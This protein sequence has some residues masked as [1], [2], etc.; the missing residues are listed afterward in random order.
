[1]MTKLIFN[2]LFFITNRVGS[3]EKGWTQIFSTR[4]ANKTTIIYFLGWGRGGGG[5]VVDTY[6]LCNTLG[7]FVLIVNIFDLK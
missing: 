1:M 6:Y 2:N 4:F 7:R 3:L 5:L